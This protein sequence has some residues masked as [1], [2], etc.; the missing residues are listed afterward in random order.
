MLNSVARARKIIIS[1]AMKLASDNSF[2]ETQESDLSSTEKSGAEQEET[3]QRKNEA[4]TRLGA[5]HPCLAMQSNSTALLAY[6][7]YC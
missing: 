1:E 4:G 3:E 7:Q 6:Q 2:Q 5:Q